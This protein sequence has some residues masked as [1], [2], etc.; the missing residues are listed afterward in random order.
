MGFSAEK[1]KKA[2]YERMKHNVMGEVKQLFRP[3]FLNRIDETIV[4]HS[5]GEKELKQ[6]TNL[7]CNEFVARVQKQM[8]IHLKVRDSVKKLVMENGKDIKFGARPLRR[9]LQTVLEDPMA[10][11]I[12]NGQIRA[13]QRVEAGTEKKKVRFY[14]ED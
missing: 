2:D 4:F 3:E 12:L 1:D 11:A 5:L 6:I 8:D 10:E 14:T 13:G 7:L 9:A